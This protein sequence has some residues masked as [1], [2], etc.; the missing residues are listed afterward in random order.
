MSAWALRDAEKSCA[1]V[2]ERAVAGEP[3]YILQGDEP[4]LMVVSVAG[5]A[6]AMKPVR[7]R[8]PRRKK[9]TLLEVLRSCPCGDELAE[10]IPDRHS[11]P[12]SYFERTGGFAECE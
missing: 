6:D 1:T 8:A 7:R 3:Q 2:F 10:L 5:I 9:K 4:L 11:F 12:P